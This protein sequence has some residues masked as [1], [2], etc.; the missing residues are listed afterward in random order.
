MSDSL[1][2]SSP[3]LALAGPGPESR[4]VP[5]AGGPMSGP[6]PAPDP[7][8]RRWSGIIAL[9]LA[10]GT[11]LGGLWA[12]ASLLGDQRWVRLQ[13][14]AAAR[15]EQAARDVAQDDALQRSETDRRAREAALERAAAD[16][17]AAVRQQLGELQGTST[18]VLEEVRALRRLQ[19]RR[20]R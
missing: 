7:W 15:T 12:A 1:S 2:T 11:L 10:A 13:A 20:Q 18:A 5:L 14:A 6:V 4:P 9:V 8:Y 19:A 16:E 17:R 3:P